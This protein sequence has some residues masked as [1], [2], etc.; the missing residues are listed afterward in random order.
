MDKVLKLFGNLAFGVALIFYRLFVFI[1][2]WG[3]IGI[4]MFHLP[5]VGYWQMFAISLF[6]SAI[7]T[8][9][10]SEDRHSVEESTQFLVRNFVGLSLVWGV[11]YLLFG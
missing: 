6:V 4:K 9:F 8:D 11:S 1:K 5:P 10:K 3:Y 7:T 2:M